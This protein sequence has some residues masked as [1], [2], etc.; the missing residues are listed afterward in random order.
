MDVSSLRRDYSLTG[1]AEADALADPI[2][3]FQ[4]WFADV[5]EGDR[6]DPTAMTLATADREGRP[7]ARIVL[8]KGY[9]ER[10]FV[11]FTNYGSRKGRDLEENPRAALVFYWPDFDRQVRVEGAVERASREESEEYFRSRPLGSRLGAWAS[12]QSAVIAGREEL[13]RRLLEV[14]ERFLA[15]DTADVPAPDFWGGYRLSPETIEFWQGRPSRL[16]DR[17]R[18]TRLPEGGWRID[19]LS[20]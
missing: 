8:L 9:D 11:F 5:L 13:E 3:Q 2:A 12:A 14:E 1:L 16:H 17:L 15:G 4:A 20:P 18:Y 6:H 7:S 19:R 10:G